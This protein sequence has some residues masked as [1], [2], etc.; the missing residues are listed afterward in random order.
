MVVAVGGTKLVSFLR[1]H[2]VYKKFHK[3]GRMVLRYVSGWTEH[4]QTYRYADHNTSGRR[5]KV[6]KSGE[7]ITLMKENNKFIITCQCM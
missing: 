1:A 3:Y 4:A 5:E 2:P 6:T 7:Y